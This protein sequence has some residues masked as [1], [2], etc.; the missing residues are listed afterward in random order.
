MKKNN[1][2]LFTVGV[3]G[4][5]QLPV[6]VVKTKLK[7]DEYLICNKKA[8]RNNIR[9]IKSDL[10]RSFPGKI[11][12]VFEEKLPIKLIPHIKDNFVIDIHTARCKTEPFIILTKLSSKH[13]CLIK[14]TGL[15]KIVIMNQKFGAGKSLI[16]F[17]K[18]GISIESGSER[19]QKTIKVINQIIDTV[20]NTKKYNNQK[21]EIFKVFNIL[22]KSNPKEFLNKKICSFKLIQ[23]DSQVTNLGKKFNFDFYP[24]LA[25]SRNYPN[26]LCLMAKKINYKKLNVKL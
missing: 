26:F 7:Q 20:K 13:F 16:D 10:N 11:N 21:F 2:V 9:F 17:A 22:Q 3:H 18:V 23:S 12:G 15:S 25:R 24:I 14:K 4:D 19:S 6:K 8:L 1:S 5:E